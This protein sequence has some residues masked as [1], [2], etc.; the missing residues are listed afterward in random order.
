MTGALNSRTVNA[1]GCWP[2]VRGSSSSLGKTP[3]LKTVIQ[4]QG[5]DLYKKISWTITPGSM[6]LSNCV[7]YQRGRVSTIADTELILM[8]AHLIV[9]Q[10]S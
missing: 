2:M 10:M 1:L 5:N 7:I 4:L 9:R 6:S 8:I 3:T